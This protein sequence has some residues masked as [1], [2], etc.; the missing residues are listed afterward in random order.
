MDLEKTF[1]TRVIYFLFFATIL[2]K[3]PN[4]VSSSNKSPPLVNHHHQWITTSNK[5]SSSV[6][7]H[8]Q[9]ITAFS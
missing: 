8:F 6:R 2:K 3:W 7:S 4:R 5:S 1:R 9:W